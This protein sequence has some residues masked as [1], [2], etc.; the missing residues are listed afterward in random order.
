MMMMKVTITKGEIMIVLTNIMKLGLVALLLLVLLLLLLVH[1]FTRA[2][3]V[4]TYE[5]R[6]AR[7]RVKYQ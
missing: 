2:I 1:L 7:N 5:Y 3:Q 6:S 4:F